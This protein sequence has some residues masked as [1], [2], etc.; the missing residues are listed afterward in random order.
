MPLSVEGHIYQYSS[1]NHANNNNIDMVNVLWRH[2]LYN[3]LFY[4]HL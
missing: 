1:I 3:S 2:F 4:L